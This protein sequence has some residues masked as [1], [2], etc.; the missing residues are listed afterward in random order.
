MSRPTSGSDPGSVMRRASMSPLL[1]PSPSTSGTGSNKEQSDI[2]DEEFTAEIDSA[3]HDLS[4][5]AALFRTKLIEEFQLL[6]NIAMTGGNALPPQY[7]SRDVRDPK[8]LT[9]LLD[10]SP[11]QL[12]K[13]QAFKRTRLEAIDR[14]LTRIRNRN[15]VPI[16]AWAGW[17]VQ[18]AMFQNLLLVVIVVNAVMVGI[19]AE[20]TDTQEDYVVLFQAMDIIDKISLFVFF[21]EIFLKWTDNFKKFWYDAWNC[22]DFAVTLGTALPEIVDAITG[23]NS[24]SLKVVL[25]Q[26]RTFRILRA[27]K[28]AVRFGSLRIIVV[29]IIEAFRSMALIMVLLLMVTFIFA[30]MGVYIFSN[31]ASSGVTSKYR[32]SFSNLGST[33]ELLFQLITLDNWNDVIHAMLETLEPIYVYLYILMWVWLGAFIF[34]NI[35][36]GIMVS[37]FDRIS[38]ELKEKYESEVKQKRM[39]QMRKRL[40]KELQS[41]K[42]NIRSSINNLAEAS[43]AIRPATAANR[44]GTPEKKKSREWAIAASPTQRTL[45]TPAGLA[46]D[47]T[48]G[49]AN[50]PT[51]TVLPRPGAPRS[52]SAD[53]LATDPPTT[54]AIGQARTEPGSM[55]DVFGAGPLADKPEGVPGSSQQLVDN[56]QQL[57]TEAHG[58]SKGWEATIRETLAALAAK[59]EETLWPRDTLFKYFQLMESL[60]ENMREYQELQ[61]MANAVLLEL[62]DT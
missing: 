62:Q 49:L 54:G 40:R 23:S 34:R 2:A 42:A 32:T 56:I 28:L 26:L 25:S 12:V 60:Q 11:H 24:G 3:F 53:V 19:V 33:L 37:N 51:A 39:D 57:L 31:F 46:A 5:H 17:V 38:S 20:L 48:P 18:S 4:T 52:A 9:K 43:T 15:K 61:S 30:V 10:E 16:G 55:A 44:L 22:F 6:E 29:T 45:A 13:F 1:R 14:R 41:A 27:L 59:A 36:V 58:V 8:M 35:F 7:N 47:P 50:R 21:L